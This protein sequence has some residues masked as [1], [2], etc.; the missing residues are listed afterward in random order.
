M[1][2]T[3]VSDKPGDCPIC[4]M[5]LVPIEP[6][7]RQRR[8]ADAA[9]SRGSADPVL[10]VADGS[11]G[12]FRQ[13]GQ[14][15]HGHGLRARLRGR[16][17]ADRGRRPGARRGDA[18]ARASQPARRAQRRGA[19]DAHRPDHPHGRP[20]D[21]RRAAPGAR[22]H[23]VRGLRRAPL[24]RLHRQV[25]DRRATRC[26]RSTAPSSSPRSR[27]TCW[28]CARRSSSAPARFPRWPRAARA[29]SRPRAS[30]SASGTSARPTS[31]SSSGPARSAARSISTRRSAASSIAEERR[32][33]HA[34]DA[35]R[36]ALRDRRPLA[37]LGAGRRLRVGPPQRSGSA[38]RRRDAVRT[39]RAA[40]GAARCRTSRRRSTRRRA[41][42]RSAST[43]TTRAAR[44]SRTCSPTC[45]LRVD[46]G[47]GLVV[48]DSAVIDTGDRR[49][50]FLD[51]PDGTI[52]PR[53]IEVGAKLAGRLPGAARPREGRPRRDR[54]PT[55]CSTRSRA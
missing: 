13:A 26:S 33:G 3:V 10:P 21:G 36:H 48:P 37:R 12:P 23:E 19:R 2:P 18:L 51:R 44:S 41:R 27:S 52:E 17:R 55:S 30:G 9:G 39:S 6:A 46:E 29:C 16:G 40:T 7:A 42:S 8:P 4:G 32:A 31:R 24:R 22:A 47:T 14:G 38:C 43:S 45:V 1:H 25:R 34:R 5:K 11:D 49:L 28:R 15:Q 53:E 20:R 50:V 54:R 35:G